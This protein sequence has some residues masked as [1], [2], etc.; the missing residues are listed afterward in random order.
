MGP[1]KK[2]NKETENNKET[3]NFKKVN[4]FFD[5]DNKYD[6]PFSLK[7]SAYNEDWE[8]LHLQESSNSTNNN[9]ENYDNRDVFRMKIK[10]LTILIY[11]K[12]G[13]KTKNK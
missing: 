5:I 12:V 11:L 9:S 2:K 13:W 6:E 10:T 8:Y 1:V 3:Q 7:I 4:T